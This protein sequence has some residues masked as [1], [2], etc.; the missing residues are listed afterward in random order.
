MPF[1]WDV[2]GSHIERLQE[3]EFK[4]KVKELI[5][6]D[7]ID[8]VNEAYG[9][10]D[11]STEQLNKIGQDMVTGKFKGLPT[12][13]KGDF[14]PTGFTQED[15]DSPAFS[16]VPKERMRLNQETGRYDLGLVPDKPIDYTPEDTSKDDR[17]I[18]IDENTAKSTGMKAG[19]WAPYWQ[20]KQFFQNERAK[21][22]SNYVDIRQDKDIKAREKIAGIKETPEERRKTA[23]ALATYK[24]PMSTPEEKDEAFKHLGGNIDEE[25]E[26]PE[27]VGHTWFGKEKINPAVTKKVRTFDKKPVV[28]PSP[29]TKRKI[30]TATNPKTKEKI[31]SLDGGQ[32]WQLAQ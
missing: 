32:T 29:T 6:K 15:V 20:I 30:M 19:T 10:G 28:Q 23:L 14:Q 4:K 18:Q 12:S 16:D 3:E 24:D 9:R 8:K 17:L 26:T 5:Y 1:T 31:Q 2:A 27:E 11:I 13:V 21:T 7:A 25:I 22:M